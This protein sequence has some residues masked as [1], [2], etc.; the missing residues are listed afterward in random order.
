MKIRSIHL[1]Q[2]GPIE[3]RVIDL[4]N[5]W[6]DG[7]HERILL[8]GPNGSGKSAVLRAMAGLWRLL[9][10]WLQ[11]PDISKNMPGQLRGWMFDHAGAIALI[12]ADAPGMP[13]DCG[14][15]YGDSL[16]FQKISHKADFWIGEK[17][18]KSGRTG[19]LDKMRYLHGNANYVELLHRNTWDQ[20]QTWAEA[21]RRLQLTTDN[22][23]S[24][25]SDTPNVIYLEAEERRWI[26]PGQKLEQLIPDDPRQ[27]WCVTYKPEA[28]WQGQLEASLLALKTLDPSR[29]ADVL[30]D[31]NKFLAGKRIRFQPTP[32]LRLAV[33]VDAAASSAQSMTARGQ[34]SHTLDELSAGER[35]VLVQIYL[36]SRWLQPGGIVLLDEPD[37][38][39]H[40][41]LIPMLLAR[42][43]TIVAGRGGQLIITSH[44][45]EIWRM[46]ETKALRVKLGGDL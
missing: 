38:H 33:D 28:N 6:T 7:L 14:I 37:L 12:V 10:H 42:V 17:I 4:T 1:H 46:Y 19:A 20:L 11:S 16:A 39:L 18:K 31:L 5:K 15:F 32:D 45:P 26:M 43:E 8:T 21:H 35:Q 25:K 27:Q 3:E 22:A 9:G 29:Y 30:E 23:H 40:P 34:T 41:S 2:V 36:I 13:G 24:P 44:L